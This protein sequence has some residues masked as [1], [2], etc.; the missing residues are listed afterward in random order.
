MI[1]L[2]LWFSLI[3]CDLFFLMIRRTPRST[4]LDTLFPYTTLFRSF[5]DSS[6]RRNARLISRKSRCEQRSLRPRYQI[7]NKVPVGGS[8]QPLEQFRRL[9]GEIGRAHV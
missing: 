8:V 7:P 9:N 6:A 3:C 5:L 4:R 1:V 2:Y